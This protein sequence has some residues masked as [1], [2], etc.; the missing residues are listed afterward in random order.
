MDFNSND[1]ESCLQAL[2]ISEEVVYFQSRIFSKFTNDLIEK[3]NNKGLPL[4]PCQREILEMIL[5]QFASKFP[6]R[7]FG[8]QS[9]IHI[10]DLK[11]MNNKELDARFSRLVE[12]QYPFYYVEYM[13]QTKIKTGHMQ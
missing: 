9:V 12:I 6:Q 2:Q 10:N 13:P 7:H 1:R 11:L 5:N 8:M 4:D 3:L